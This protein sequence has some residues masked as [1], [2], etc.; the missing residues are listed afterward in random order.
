MRVHTPLHA[1][2]HIS[3]LSYIRSIFMTDVRMLKDTLANLNNIQEAYAES[4]A[5]ERLTT[6]PLQKN[7]HT[8]SCVQLDMHFET[9]L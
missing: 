7:S 4:A 2:H 6:R 1:G 8:C 3:A 5:A 9:H